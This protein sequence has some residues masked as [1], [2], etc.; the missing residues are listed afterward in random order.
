MFIYANVLNLLQISGDLRR[1][2]APRCADDVDVTSSKQGR[3][4]TDTRARSN[5]WNEEKERTKIQKQKA[6]PHRG[7]LLITEPKR[8]L[9]MAHV[10]RRPCKTHVVKRT[11]AMLVQTVPNDRPSEHAGVDH[12]IIIER[13]YVVA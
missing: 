3:D 12:V 7:T 6:D 2:Q 10:P 8:V 11:C 1:I 9:A 4:N 5:H 13:K